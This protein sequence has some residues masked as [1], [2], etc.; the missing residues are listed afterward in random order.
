MQNDEIVINKV[1]FNDVESVFSI[2][3]CEGY[4]LYWYQKVWGILEIKGLTAYSSQF[5]YAVVIIRAITLSML[6]EE[7]CQLAFD[8]HCEY[9]GYCDDVYDMIPDIVIG[10]L[11]ARLVEADYTED[12]NY[13]LC[14]IAEK[15]RKSVFAAIRSILTETDIFIGMYCTNYT[16]YKDIEEEEE[17]EINSYEDYWKMIE[18]EY[19]TIIDSIPYEANAAFEWITDGSLSVGWFY[20]STNR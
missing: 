8:E 9:D 19:E 2:V 14:M 18:A 10:Q 20:N 13:A 1:S 15:E 6:Y 16:P 4:E 3:W 7:F 12:L 11:Y 17:Y 5:E